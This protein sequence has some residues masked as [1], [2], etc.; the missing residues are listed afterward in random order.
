MS[1]DARE[2]AL[3]FFGMFLPQG[4][5]IAPLCCADIVELRIGSDDNARLLREAFR[6]I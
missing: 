1:L 5:P 6:D 4:D 3:M 2:R